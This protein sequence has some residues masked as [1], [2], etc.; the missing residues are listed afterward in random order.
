MPVETVTQELSVASTDMA[1]LLVVCLTGLGWRPVTVNDR[2]MQVIATQTKAQRP[3]SYEFFATLS[4]APN[5]EGCSLTLEVREE[6]NNWSITHCKA[7]CAE[8]LQRIVESS[9]RM[10]KANQNQ[11]K[12]TRYGSARWATHEDIVKAGYWNNADDSRRLVVSPGEDDNYVTISPEDSIMHA[13][14]CGPTGSGKTTSVF[15][16]NL[17]ERLDTSAIVTEVTA[18]N[19][20]PHLYAMTSGYR[21]GAGRQQIYYFNPDDLS[22]DCINPI[23]SVKGYSEAQNLAKLIVENTTSKN[24]YGDDVWPRSE[25]NLLAI[26]IAHAAALGKDLGFVRSMLREGPDDLLSQMQ[27]SPVEE[28][29]GEYYGFH[30]TS[31]EGFRYG[32]F[33]S[34]MQRLGL[35]VNPRVVALTSR[36]TIDLEALTQEKFTFY[37]A[38]PVRKTH[39]KPVAA[40]MFNFIL[41]QAE[42]KNFKYPLYLSLDEFTNFGMIPGIV[43]RLGAIRHKEIGVVLGVQDA[44]QLEIV[45]GREAASVIFSQ[46]GTRM[47]FRPRSIDVAE[48]ISRMAGQQTI[49]E[50]KVSSTGQIQEKE[51]GRPLI[52]PSEVMA[53][54]DDK[55]L[56]FTPKTPPML[57]ERFTWR[58][59]EMAMKIPGMVKPEVEVDDRLVK[60][61]QELKQVHP[62]QVEGEKKRR[63]E[64]N[65]TPVS[66]DNVK[67][68]LEKELES[69]LPE[70]PTPVYIE[71]EIEEEPKPVVEV[72]EEEKSDP[73]D[74][75][76]IL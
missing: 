21:A 28:V 24:N 1:E 74:N 47:F 51:S 9:E 72:E 14:A 34:L 66:D 69:S 11:P 5:D 8:I 39:L 38:V 43:D 73:D 23:D 42:E 61:C 75:Y 50:R 58:D 27:K 37:M 46:L 67:S 29:R 41:Q 10:I 36:T 3:F 59:Y 15:I 31:R 25:M 12:P 53:M 16:P 6:R 71:S 52:D 32:V 33:A 48:K 26:F 62:W 57:M 4:W 54:P 76:M 44:M 7:K 13:F 56:V 19:E 70:E 60:D 17:I 63:E 40:L 22:S 45:Y 35:W 65:E 64:M 68:E 18:G 2:L 55:V 20:S 49:Y 30:K